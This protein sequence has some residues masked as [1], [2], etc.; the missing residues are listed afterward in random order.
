MLRGS[1]SY[2]P[3]FPKARV[4]VLFSGG[5]DC[6]V[7]ALLADK[8]LPEAEV[9]VC[10]AEINLAHQCLLVYRPPEC[11][12]REPSVAGKCI[13]VRRCESPRSRYV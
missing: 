13:Q 10:F 7:L 4:G 3:V 1:L 5:L 9:G 12:F 8:Y 11:R 2:R 6:T